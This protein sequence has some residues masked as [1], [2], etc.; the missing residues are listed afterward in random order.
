MCVCVCVCVCVWGGCANTR[1]RASA[2]GCVRNEATRTPGT[3]CGASRHTSARQHTHLKLSLSVSNPSL[4]S[5]DSIHSRSTRASSLARFSTPP[6][7]RESLLPRVSLR[8]THAHTHGDGQ[9]FV[10]RVERVVRSTRP[11]GW[12]EHSST[13]PNK[14]KNKTKEAGSS[15]SKRRKRRVIKWIQHLFKI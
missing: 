7:L 5:R 4:R 6:P 13:T 15:P 2:C 14:K 3:A 1:T 8:R 10:G 12:G 9:S 11:G